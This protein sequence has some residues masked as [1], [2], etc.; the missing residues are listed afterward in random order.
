MPDNHASTSH[1]SS[2][3]PDVA[4]QRPDAPTAERRSAVR[5][6]GLPIFSTELLTTAEKALLELTAREHRRA[7]DRLDDAVRAGRVADGLAALQ[8]VAQLAPMDALT[9]WRLGS[10][11]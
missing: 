2:A 11:R 6:T 1:Q 3:L 7:A 9:A 4:L 8:E 10:N 5:P